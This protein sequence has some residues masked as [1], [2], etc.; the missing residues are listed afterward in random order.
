MHD[1]VVKLQ[2]KFENLPMA[3]VLI[4]IIIATK[5]SFVTS[6]ESFVIGSLKIA[7]GI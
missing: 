6:M 2:M 7:V 4:W 5:T 1:S 3:C